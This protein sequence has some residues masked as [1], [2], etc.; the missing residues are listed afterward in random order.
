MW[1]YTSPWK[2]FQVTL[3]HSIGNNLFKWSPCNRRL[4]TEWAPTE[5]VA[6][7]LIYSRKSLGNITKDTLHVFSVFDRS[8]HWSTTSKHQ[9]TNIRRQAFYSPY[10]FSRESN[11]I[12]LILFFQFFSKLSQNL[13]AILKVYQK[14]TSSLLCV[15]LFPDAASDACTGNAAQTTQMQPLCTQRFMLSLTFTT[16][17]TRLVSLRSCCKIAVLVLNGVKSWNVSNSF[18]L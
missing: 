17:H 14:I 15:S 18:T 7:S 3:K 13:L 1:R 9:T 2:I 5:T 12:F 6:H 8:A 10:P 11:F 16:A 4:S